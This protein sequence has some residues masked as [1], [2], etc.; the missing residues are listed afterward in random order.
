MSKRDMPD[1]MYQMP[2]GRN[3][4]IAELEAEVAML[5]A[6]IA[7]AKGRAK[8]CEPKKKRAKK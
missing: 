1:Y 8:P 3:L 6:S 5:R 4:R 7:F 2:D